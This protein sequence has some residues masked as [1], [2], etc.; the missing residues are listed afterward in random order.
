[1]QCVDIFGEQYVNW[2]KGRLYGGHRP[3]KTLRTGGIMANI[4]P[5]GRGKSL[6]ASEQGN[7][8][9]QCEAK[10]EETKV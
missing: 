10:C 3:V 7:L 2:L 9:A 5:T 6:K 4:S 8:K 1:M